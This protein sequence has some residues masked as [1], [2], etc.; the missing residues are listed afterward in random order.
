MKRKF[1][2]WP[3]TDLDRGCSLDRVEDECA[4]WGHRRQDHSVAQ[5]VAQFAHWTLGDLNEIGIGRQ[6][7]Q[8]PTLGADGVARRNRVLYEVAALDQ[9]EQMSVHRSFGD[10]QALRE[11]SDTQL[12]SGKGDRLEYIKGKLHRAHAGIGTLIDHWQ[13]PSLSYCV[14]EHKTLY[15]ISVMGIK[16]QIRAFDVICPRIRP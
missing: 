6:P 7:R 16:R 12:L 8:Q 3:N 10:L 9:R 1:A 2:S 15:P 4:P 13:S 5:G 11:L 14:R